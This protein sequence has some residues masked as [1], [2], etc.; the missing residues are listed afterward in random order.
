ME[1]EP[2]SEEHKGPP[3]GTSEADRGQAT[4]E[5]DGRSELPCGCAEEAGE[6][7]ERE[8]ESCAAAASKGAE[9]KCPGDPETERGGV[10]W[11]ETRKLKKTHSWKM[12]R[13]QDP[14]EDDDVLE[15]DSSAESLFP[16]QA[17]KEWTSS[18]FAELF[19]AEDWQDIA[20]EETPRNHDV[21]NLKIK[22]TNMKK[23]LSV[24][25]LEFLASPEH[26]LMNWIN[27][28]WSCVRVCLYLFTQKTGF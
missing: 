13:F 27:L 19:A 21:H 8:R 7:R 22:R 11:R 26:V 16:D 23:T 25:H 17:T 18:T 2:R 1:T 20:G 9:T 5:R 12:V 4:W 24:Y 10:G 28:N 15:R 14:S 6:L 3:V